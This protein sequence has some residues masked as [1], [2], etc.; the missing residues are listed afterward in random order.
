MQKK[1]KC[2]FRIKTYCERKNVPL[3][4]LFSTVFCLWSC[5]WRVTAAPPGAGCCPSFYC[6]RRLAAA[7]RSTALGGWLLP[8]VLLHWAVGCCPSFC[9]TWRLAAARRSAALGGWLLPL[10]PLHWRLAAAPRSAAL[11]AGCYLSFHCTW[12][13]AAASRSAALAADCCPSFR[14]M[15]HSADGRIKVRPPHTSDTTYVCWIPSPRP[16]GA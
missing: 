5:P 10:V 16:S 15:A 2:P 13:L 4:F 11:T 7:P 12:R 3:T 8:L 14:C 9:C 1:I 6:T